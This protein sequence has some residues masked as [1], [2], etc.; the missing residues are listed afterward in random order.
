MIVFTHCFLRFSLPQNNPR[1]IFI[2][3]FQYLINFFPPKDSL[4]QK[5]CKSHLLP[6]P[7]G[8]D[9]VYFPVPVL[10]VH[11]KAKSN[12]HVKENDGFSKT[13]QKEYKMPHI[14]DLRN[15]YGISDMVSLITM[16]LL[17]KL[18]NAENDRST[19]YFNSVNLKS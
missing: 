16:G 10:F 13:K 5:R 9:L 3:L 11:S 2:W 6:K 17:Q 19:L 12:R 18:L 7:A 15:N 1:I 14:F 4:F 8:S